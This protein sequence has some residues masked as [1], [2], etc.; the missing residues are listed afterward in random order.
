[1]V[2]KNAVKGS[3][4]VYIKALPGKKGRIRVLTFDPAKKMDVTDVESTVIVRTNEYE[5]RAFSENYYVTVNI[6]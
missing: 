5:V 2:W 4:N 3:Q 1:M 6:K